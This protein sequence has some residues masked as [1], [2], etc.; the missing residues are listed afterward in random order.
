[1]LAE[2]GWVVD[3]V[4]YGV[5]SRTGDDPVVRSVMERLVAGGSFKVV[6]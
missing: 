1:L 4:R 2:L 6:A 3:G 5:A